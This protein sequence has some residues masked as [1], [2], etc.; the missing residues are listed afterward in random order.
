MSN[1]KLTLTLAAALCLVLLPLSARAADADQIKAQHREAARRYLDALEPGI[2]LGGTVV[3]N[4]SA[5]E[6]N[7][8]HY[9]GAWLVEQRFGPISWRGYTGPE[10]SWSGSN[11]GLPYE[12]E[13]SDSPANSAMEIMTDGRYL[14]DPYWEH[15]N[16]VEETAGG[17]VFGFTPP[18]LPPI[19]VLLYSDPAEPEYLQVMSLAVPL[20]Q[21]DDACV[22]YR[23]Y[24]YYVQD[25]AGRI[26]TAR[27]TGREVD[28]GGETINYVEYLVEDTGWPEAR[29]AGMQFD[30]TRQPFSQSAAALEAP[31]KIPARTERGYFIVPLTFA[32]S[33]E[34]FWFLL[35][36]GAS[37]SL[38]A[39]DAAAA[40]GLEPVLS[41]PTHG[42]G[43]RAE[44]ALGMC[45]AASLGEAGSDS[46]APLDGFTA[47][48]IP[49][50]NDVL[51]A[52]GFYGVS[53]LLGI[54]PLHQ[55][56]I[57]F[58][59][60]GRELLLTPPQLFDPAQLPQEHTYIMELDVEDLVYCPARVNDELEGEV[61]IDSGLQQ[62]LALLR[63]TAEF[64]GIEMQTIDERANTVVGGVRNFEYVA[65]PSFE[66]LTLGI[67]EGHRE[68]RMETAMASL[69]EDDHGTLSGRGLLGFVG[70]TM[71]IDVKV[72]LDLFGQRM[73]YEVPPEMVAVEDA[74]EDNGQADGEPWPAG[75]EEEQAEEEDGG[76][77]ELPVP[78]N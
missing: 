34:T 36:T 65:I 56:V 54:A 30:F 49:E 78:I 53:G 73:Y 11:Y 44:F 31:V 10:G 22:T 62:D 19:E 76:G 42:H 51:D 71:F 17:F 45:T 77:T 38:F 21:H 75:P 12:V 58:D 66:L 7:A 37:S 41:L 48:A 15:F 28:A 13:P 55:Y 69:T 16:Y 50:G 33:D 57:T 43:S 67:P 74:A 8:Y 5:G 39:P 1:L 40:A 26:L 18:E 47:T 23:A 4:E 3:R 70:M 24:Y 29:P 2:T 25:E 72:T 27:E 63:E 60:P 46:Q 61:V 9:E 68:L 64:N 59:H 35:D 32:G 52:F 6:F 20:A 14:D